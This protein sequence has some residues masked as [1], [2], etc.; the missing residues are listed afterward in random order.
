[1]SQVLFALCMYVFCSAFDTGLNIFSSFMS[2]QKPY[3]ELDLILQKESTENS[4]PLE[5]QASTVAIKSDG[6]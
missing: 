5:N 1:M 2:T 4:F 6:Y 3:L